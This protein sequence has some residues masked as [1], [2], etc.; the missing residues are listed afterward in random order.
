VDR[1]APT[2]GG[3]YRVA[4]GRFYRCTTRF[5]RRFGLS[6]RREAVSRPDAQSDQ[7]RGNATECS[8]IGCKE[9][10]HGCPRPQIQLCEIQPILFWIAGVAAPCSSR[11]PLG[12]GY[13]TAP[14]ER[15]C[16]DP[17]RS[18]PNGDVPRA[19][20]RA[21]RGRIADAIRKR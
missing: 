12:A 14:I 18:R 10:A 2:I 5:S 19:P 11:S 15:C 3:S 7:N 4:R 13:S 9:P 8:S 17:R 6:S 21:G 1:L 16:E 20:K